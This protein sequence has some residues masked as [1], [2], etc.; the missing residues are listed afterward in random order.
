MGK[1]DDWCS[2]KGLNNRKKGMYEKEK[3]SRK[4]CYCFIFGF[5]ALFF[6][7]IGSLYAERAANAALINA[8]YTKEGRKSAERKAAQTA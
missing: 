4:C 5:S 7:G 3:K 1:R 2:S 8:D 6:L